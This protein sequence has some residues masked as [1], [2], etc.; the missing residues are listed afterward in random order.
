M[1]HVHFVGG[2]MLAG[3]LAVL[4][5]QGDGFEQADCT[6]ERLQAK[7]PRG[8]TIT[9]AAMVNAADRVPE[10]C[11][12]DGHAESSGNTVTFRLGL[13]VRWNGKFYFQGVGGLAGTIGSLNTGLARG[14]AAASTD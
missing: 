4:R 6:V 10:Y 9:G 7:A 14:Y 8:T 5:A 1:K 11:R 3:S 13:P 12:V 2:V